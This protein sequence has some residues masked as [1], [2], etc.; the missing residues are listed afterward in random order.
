MA[1]LLIDGSDLVLSLTLGEKIAGFRANIRVPLT[2]VQSA[3]AVKYPWPTLRGWRMAGI[4]IPGRVALGTRRHAEGYDFCALHRQQ[5][6]VQVDL[7]TGRFSRLIV[8]V[9]SGSDAGSEADHIADAAGVARS[10]PADQA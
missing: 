7:N 5:E 1:R 2:A 6:A 8:G 9:P 4:A 10:R 3:R